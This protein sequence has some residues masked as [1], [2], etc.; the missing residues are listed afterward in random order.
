MTRQLPSAPNSPLKDRQAE[1]LSQLT[2][3][4]GQIEAA[5]A[6]FAAINRRLKGEPEP[7]LPAPAA[8]PA[9]VAVPAEAAPAVE[10]VPFPRLARRP[11]RAKAA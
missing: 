2:A 4:E 7:A 10:T 3:L 5:V 6:E 1:A 11:G 8:A 9:T